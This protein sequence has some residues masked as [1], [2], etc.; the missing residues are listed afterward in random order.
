MG[1][2][3]DFQ[4]PILALGLGLLRDDQ[5]AEFDV[6]GLHLE[7]ESA[8]EYT[9]RIETRQD[10]TSFQESGNELHL[11]VNSFAVDVDDLVNAISSDIFTAS[12]TGSLEIDQVEWNVGGLKIE[13]SL[14]GSSNPEDFDEALEILAHPE[15]DPDIPWFEGEKVKVTNDTDGSVKYYLAIQDIEDDPTT[16]P[17]LNGL[18]WAETNDAPIVTDWSGNLQIYIGDPTTITAEDIIA[19]KDEF[20][21]ANFDITVSGSGTLDLPSKPIK[22]G[23]ADFFY[24]EGATAVFTTS[25]H[26]GEA[27]NLND[28][29]SAQRAVEN[30]SR[31]ISELAEQVDKLSQNMSKVNL[32][33]EHY[34]RQIAIRKDIGPNLTEEVIQEESIRLKE[35]EILRNYHMSLLHKVMRVNEDMVRMLVL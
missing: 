23:W 3:S 1:T 10:S 19:V 2:G 33:E 15:W 8:G 14:P 26:Y 4:I 7:A 32:A 13:G 25:G 22:T 27:L 9:L 12:G 16:S 20:D 11:S 21:L 35:I 28:A 17:G 24:E 31:E 6:G 30:L 5:K 34:G 18:E 29:D